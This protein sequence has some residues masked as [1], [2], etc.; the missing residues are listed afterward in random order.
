MSTLSNQTEFNM[1]RMWL[2]GK[3]SN[4]IL[5]TLKEKYGTSYY[6][7]LRKKDDTNIVLK[8]LT[9]DKQVRYGRQR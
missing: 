3:E 7:A 6:G 9:N 5:Q 2:E 1:M 8:N 4:D